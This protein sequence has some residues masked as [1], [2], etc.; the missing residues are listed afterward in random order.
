MLLSSDTNPEELVLVV[1]VESI[2]TVFNAG[3]VAG[4]GKRLLLSLFKT[5]IESL[6]SEASVDALVG[7]MKGITVEAAKESEF[8]FKDLEE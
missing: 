5:I 3:N 6:E 4:D 8:A 2:G 7:L 1:N